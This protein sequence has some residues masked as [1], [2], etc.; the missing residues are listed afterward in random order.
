MLIW[1]TYL[2]DWAHYKIR[3]NKHMKQNIETYRVHIDPVVRRLMNEAVG[4]IRSEASSFTSKAKD[5]YEAG[6]E[7]I[8]TSADRAA[9][10]HYLDG[11]TESFPGCGLVGEEDGLRRPCTIGGEDFYFTIDPLDG[12]K[13]FARQ[14]SFGVGTMIGVVHN[15]KIIA[16]YIGDV[17]TGEIFSYSPTTTPTRTRWGV[18]TPLLDHA[19]MAPQK[20]VIM[21]NT[22]I[23]EFPDV[24]QRFV[25][26]H[27]KGGLWK[28]SEV[29]GGSYGTFV[30]RLWKGEVGA[31]L[32]D[33]FYNTPWDRTPVAGLS[34]ALGYVSIRL[35]PKTGQVFDVFEFGPITQ[36]EEFPWIRIDVHRDNLDQVL[37][38]FADQGAT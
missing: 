37:K 1:I 23:A 36:V 14:Q 8:V 18:T 2:S 6:K 15:D 10:K 24:I 7:D 17:N 19:A 38:W 9:Q 31:L 4:I 5:H 28:D 29:G 33:P 21:S 32:Y 34:S 20:S 27:D 25:Q 26:K 3:K 22:P 16:G 35:D 30:A 11:L 13:A 12:T